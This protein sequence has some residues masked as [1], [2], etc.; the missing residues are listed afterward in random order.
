[1]VGRA[2]RHVDHIG[3]VVGQAVRVDAGRAAAVVRVVE[4]HR[5]VDGE[6]QSQT[7]AGGGDGA[8]G[9]VGPDIHARGHASVAGAG[10][11]LEAADDIGNVGAV[12][13]KVDRVRVID[14]AAVGGP[15]LADPVPAA[16]DL[17]RRAA[18]AA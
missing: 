1:A 5:I 17:I 3:R 13:L 18:V 16:D 9:L 11:G 12:T 6:Q 2:E 10:A 7:L 8:A 14:S 15:E 4:V